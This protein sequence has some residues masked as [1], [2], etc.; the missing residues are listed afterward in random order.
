M[1]H[2]N[3]QARDQQPD[4][5]YTRRYPGTQAPLASQNAL[6]DEAYRMA[7]GIKEQ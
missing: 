2:D 7:K 1:W 5:S 4:G 6:Y 3:V